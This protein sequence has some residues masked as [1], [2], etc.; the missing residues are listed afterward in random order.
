MS[1]DDFCTKISGLLLSQPE[2]AL[3]I[4][5]YH[6]EKQ[7]DV[8]MS[9]GELATIIR[10]SGLGN[11]HSTQLREAIVRTGKVIPTKSGLR[12]KV[13]ARSQIRQSIESI[14]GAAKPAV[15]QELGYLPQDVWKDTR[16]Y[17]E[18]VCVQLN[19]C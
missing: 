15:D 13:L 6:D 1:L 14:L 7:P 3:A 18:K 2:Q 19:G 4:L 8:V 5:W 12:L 9:A 17:I 16:G 11:P 10:N